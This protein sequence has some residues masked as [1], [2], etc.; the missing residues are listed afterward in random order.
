MFIANRYF[1]RKPGKGNYNTNGVTLYAGKC[2]L[3]TNSSEDGKSA[4]VIVEGKEINLIY[5][6]PEIYYDL[7]PEN[8]SVLETFKFY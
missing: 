6:S 2:Y 8:K 4:I 3:C 1:T 7:V 5:D